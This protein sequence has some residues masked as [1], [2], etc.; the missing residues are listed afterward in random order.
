MHTNAAANNRSLGRSWAFRPFS[1]QQLQCA[2]SSRSFR[3]PCSL[4]REP[5]A[6]CDSA[7]SADD[8]TASRLTMNRRSA[9]QLAALTLISPA[10]AL[11]DALPATAAA[12]PAAANFVT[13]ASGL[14]LQDIRQSMPASLSVS[15]I[16][17]DLWW[18]TSSAV[19]FAVLRAA[20]REGSGAN[21]VAGNR[22]VINWSGRTIGYQVLRAFL[23]VFA[24]LFWCRINQSLQAERKPLL[25]HRASASTTPRRGMTPSNSLSAEDRWADEGWHAFVQHGRAVD[26]GHA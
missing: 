9:C 2:S 20:S 6:S 5:A 23:S 11:H 10:L 7:R 25:E 24:A 18:I 21:P 8:A 12:A 17:V 26:A 22:A 1:S 13:T 19:G 3:R 15:M 16:L 14:K 4:P